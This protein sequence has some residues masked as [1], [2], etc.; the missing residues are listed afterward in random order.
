MASFNGCKRYGNFGQ[1]RRRFFSLGPAMIASCAMQVKKDAIY[2]VSEIKKGIESQAPG[3]VPFIP[4]ADSTKKR[5]G[6][7]KALIDTQA[8]MGAV[9]HVPV[10]PITE[11]IGLLRTQMHKAK[12]GKTMSMANLG[13]IH[14][15]PYYKASGKGL[16]RIPARSFI[17][18]VAKKEMPGIIERFKAAAAAPVNVP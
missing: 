1:Y 17:G 4:L 9:T 16:K 6:S 3:G 15:Q 2:L 7:S 8:M 14:E 10:R 11:F 18:P 5:K 12:D 13:L